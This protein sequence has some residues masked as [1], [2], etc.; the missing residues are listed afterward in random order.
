[1]G[2]YETLRPLKRGFDDFFGFLTG[3]HRYF[4][5]EYVFNSVYELKNQGDAYR[6]K[7]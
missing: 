3:G 6:T 5:D 2:A 4:P 7:L 1:M